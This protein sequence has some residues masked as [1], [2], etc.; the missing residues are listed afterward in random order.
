MASSDHTP[1]DH[2]PGFRAIRWNIGWILRPVFGFGMA[3]VAIAAVF[4]LAPPHFRAAAG[5]AA[6]PR[7]RANGTAWW[8]ESKLEP[9]KPAIC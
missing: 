3:I 8:S 2:A 4:A 6:D 5:G 7:R 9:V 1:N